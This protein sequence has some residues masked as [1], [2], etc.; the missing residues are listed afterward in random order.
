LNKNLKLEKILNR[1]ENGRKQ[2][3]RFDS[4]HMTLVIDNKKWPCKTIHKVLRTDSKIK[5]YRI[6]K[7][8]TYLVDSKHPQF[9]MEFSTIF[10][11]DIRETQLH[12]YGIVRETQLPH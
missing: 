3:T 11:G 10:G 6:K 7:M 2:F 5:S 1:S 12:S 8:G 9:F 4:K